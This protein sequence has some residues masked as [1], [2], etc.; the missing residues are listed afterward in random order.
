M[1]DMDYW[2]SWSA[3]VAEENPG[4]ASW[5]KDMDYWISWSAPVAE[6]NPGLASWMKDP[7]YWNN[8]PGSG[9]EVLEEI[10]SGIEPWM[11]DPCHW[12]FRGVSHEGRNQA[13]AGR[14]LC[15]IPQE[16]DSTA[17]ES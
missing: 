4:L 12:D 2:I 13:E 1:K 14:R 8:L 7:G 6:E 17:R 10:V 3:P 11:S 15:M 5:M 9:Q 16:H